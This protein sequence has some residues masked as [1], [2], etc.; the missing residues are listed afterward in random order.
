MKFPQNTGDIFQSFPNN[1]FF[2][3]LL[4]LYKHRIFPHKNVLNLFLHN[5]KA[6]TCIDVLETLFPIEVTVIISALC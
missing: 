1:V 2:Y 4:F 3:Y 6:Q 5:Y